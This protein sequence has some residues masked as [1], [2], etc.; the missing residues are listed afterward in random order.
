ME[1]FN[2]E[3]EPLTFSIGFIQAPAEEVTQ[4]FVDF[5]TRLKRNGKAKKLT[6]TL[7]NNLELL[8]PLTSSNAL[9][10][11]HS[12][13][14]PDWTAL[15]DGD[16]Q[17]HGVDQRISYLATEL[18][19]NGYFFGK[20]VRDRPEHNFL[21]GT[22]FQKCDPSTTLGISRSVDLIENNPN[23]WYFYQ[24][25]EPLP[26]EQTQN[27]TARRK[28]DRLTP[29]ML[30]DY[31]TAIGLHPWDENF[32]TTPAYLITNSQALHNPTTLNQARTQLG[33]NP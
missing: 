1:L 10:L 8:Q 29:Q 33:L 25:G 26:F 14:N 13:L 32:Y 20:T 4:F 3:L 21:A 30:E 27:Y 28:K 24:D 7:R 22:H 17:G 15:F 5:F 23:R 9:Y 11:V 31:A 12:T 16:K 18:N 2:R 6:G 19:T